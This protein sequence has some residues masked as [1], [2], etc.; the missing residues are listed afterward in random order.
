MSSPPVFPSLLSWFILFV[1]T[2]QSWL[3]VLVCVEYFDDFCH[4]LHWHIT[5]TIEWIQWRKNVT[6]ILSSLFLYF[7][8]FLSCNSTWIQWTRKLPLGSRPHL[9]NDFCVWCVCVSVDVVDSLNNHLDNISRYS[10]LHYFFHR[11][12]ATESILIITNLYFFLLIVFGGALVLGSNYIN[13]RPACLDIL[14]PILGDNL[15]D[16]CNSFGQKKLLLMMM[17][18]ELW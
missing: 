12:Y 14:I 9:Y 2:I 16:E 10:T 7:S 13:F 17:D 8:Y 15:N 6:L 11:F 3:V 18:D 4:L 5:W 1:T